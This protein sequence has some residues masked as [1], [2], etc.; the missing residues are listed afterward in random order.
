MKIL[1]DFFPIALFFGAYKLYGIYAGTAVL[2]AATVLQMALVYAIDRRLQTM[3]KV[4]LA[5]ILLFGTL[6]L[7]LQDERFIKWKPTVLYGAL[8]LALA[9]GLWGLRRNFLEMLLGNQL[10][11]APGVWLRLNIAWIV[12]C[13]LMSALNAYVV[14]NFSTDAWVDFKLWGYAFPLVFL[15]GQGVYIAPHLKDDEPAA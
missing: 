14:L 2:M 5:L 4:T 11:L 3:H 6:T 12:Y 9:V 13:A 10:R 8:A 7:A 15:I 1:L